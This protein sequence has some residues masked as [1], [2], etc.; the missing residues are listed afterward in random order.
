MKR[1]V[2]TEMLLVSQKEK[3]ARR[4]RFHPKTTVIKGMNDTGKSSLLKSIYRCFGASVPV[5]DSWKT[6]NVKTLVRFQVGGAAYSVLNSGSHYAAFDCNSVCIG[7]FDSVT[8]GLGPFLGELLDFGLTLRSRDMQ[9]LTPPPPAYLFLPFYFDQDKSWSRNWDSFDR[10]SQCH[11][12]KSD[13]VQYHTGI[14]PNEYYTAKG[15]KVVVDE[16]LTR[17][18]QRLDILRGIERNIDDA[19]TSA[20]FD[21]DINQYREQIERLLLACEELKL[22]EEDLKEA[23]VSHHNLRMNLNVRMKIAKRARL[24]LKEDYGFAAESMVED[25]IDCPTCGAEYD[26]LFAERFE[27]ARDE[28]RCVEMIGQISEEIKTVE[29][30]IKAEEIRYRDNRKDLEHITE[31]LNRKQGQVALQDI[32][33]NQGRKQVRELLRNQKDGLLHQIEELGLRIR[34]LNEELKTFEDKETKGIIIDLYRTSMNESLDRLAV[35]NLPEASYSKIDSSIRE[36]GSDL[37]RALLAYYFS[38]LRVIFRYSTS[39]ICPI[40]MDAPIQQEQDTANHE[41]IL[42]FIR[43]NRP[44]DSQLILGVVD[45]KS[46]DFGGS[47]IELDK[48]NGV[49]LQ[50]E[51]G[52]VME[53]FRPL[54]DACL[55]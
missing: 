36:Q 14:R 20:E 1:F 25:H 5:H 9:P 50:E 19:I 29:S 3:G 54:L 10:L 22:K 11:N 15:R 7:E 23:L 4:I 33:E 41:R 24:E 48:K 8:R 12:W 16:E 38:I 52:D 37:P 47:V 46:V 44:T 2:L 32:I 31:I 21:F 55:H 26:N 13:V 18:H 30:T 35:H 53:E 28:D 6:A 39:A 17:L 27:I 49:L 34:D 45:D 51:F 42:E 43:D 40:V